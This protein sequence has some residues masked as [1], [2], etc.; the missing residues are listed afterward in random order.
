VN[1]RPLPRVSELGVAALVL[2]AID[3][4]TIAGSVPHRPPMAVVWPLIGA[5]ALLM[6]VAAASLA[7]TAAFAWR[8]FFLVGR[9]ALLGYVVIAGMIEYAFVYDHTPEPQM[10]ALSTV[11]LLFALDVPLLLGFAVARHQPAA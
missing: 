7:R 5:A 10:A 2:C 11:L 6:L 4:I 9:W 1:E 8:S 3:V